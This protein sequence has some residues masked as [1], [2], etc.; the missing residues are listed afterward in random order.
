MGI[1][2]T[3]VAWEATVL[4]LN[5]TRPWRDY[6]GR[7][8]RVQP[9][10]MNPYRNELEVALDALA[11]TRAVILAGYRRVAVET[12]HDGTDVTAADR[13][14]ET[15]LRAVLARHFP[16]DHVFGEEHGGSAEAARSGRCWICD[17]ID[18]TTW[19]TLGLP[20]FSTLIALCVDGEPVLG[21]A[22]FPALD[23]TWY[24][25]PGAGAWVRRARDTATP[26]RVAAPAALASAFG[27]ASGIHDSDW[28]P[29]GGAA[30]FDLG[31]VARASRRFRF[32][33]DAMQHLLVA[34]GKLDYAIDQRMAPWDSA[35]LVPIIQE[36][37][38][39]VATMD[40]ERSAVTFGGSLVSASHPD[41]LESVV[42]AA[43]WRGVSS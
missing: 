40:G 9:S 22:D 43:A 15:A 37:G 38:G 19:F 18:G 13:D 3:L 24:A 41:L 30:A 23:E 21:V 34:S 14:A 1:E 26:V 20:W 16:G 31:A 29:R 25:A 10:R 39:V 36:A 5:Y 8:G 17:P 2:P 27:S 33:G 7:R 11:A 28:A 12:K 6:A 4:P 35:A 42:Q 32:C